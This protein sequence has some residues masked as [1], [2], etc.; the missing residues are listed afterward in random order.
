[1]K[2]RP[3][4]IPL[5]KQELAFIVFGALLSLSAGLIADLAA[6]LKLNL[7][8]G[9]TMGVDMVGL[10]FIC[11]IGCAACHFIAVYSDL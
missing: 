2:P 5:L 3:R 8:A 10:C 4:T 6:W 11:V 9:L 1:M 7:Q